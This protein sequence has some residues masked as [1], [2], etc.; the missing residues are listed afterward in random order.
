[1]YKRQVNVEFNYSTFDDCYLR[2]CTFNSCTF[3]GCKFIASNFEGSQ[4][5]GGD[6]QYSIFRFTNITNELLVNNCPSYDN[7]KFKFARNLRTNFQ[8]IGDID[9]VNKAILVELESTKSTL[10]KAW[11]S[12]ESYY[13]S[14]Y[15]GW[16]RFF[17]FVSWLKF[18]IGEFV[19][20]NGESLLKLGRAVLLTLVLISIIDTFKIGETDSIKSYLS[21]LT[22]S[23]QLFFSIDKPEYY[24]KQYL[25]L[26]YFFRLV[27]FGLFMAI[28]IKRFSKR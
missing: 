15:K 5:I 17:K 21:G 16:D 24:S 1:M 27:F 13:R 23:P 4:F 3:V 22:N 10:Y 2:S 7:L 25:S 28:V 12:N 9:G 19:W 14:K 8:S 11:N 26:I 18:K 6:F 20:G